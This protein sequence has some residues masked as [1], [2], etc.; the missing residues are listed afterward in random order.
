MRNARLSQVAHA[1]R[2][3]PSTVA[4]FAL[5]TPAG[6]VAVWLIEVLAGIEVPGEVGAALGALLGAVL[7]YVFPGG[8]SADTK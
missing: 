2:P 5:G 7:G 4:G 1:P 3:S 6:I 8:I